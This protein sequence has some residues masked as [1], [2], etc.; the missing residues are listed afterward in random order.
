VTVLGDQLI[1]LVRRKA[2][3]NPDFVYTPPMGLGGDCNYMHED[4]PGCIIGHALAGAGLI[5]R[6][7]A[8]NPG[9]AETVMTLN[10][11]LELGL[12]PTEVT[13]LR[14]VQAWQDTSS[15]W[16]RAVETADRLYPLDY[17]QTDSLGLADIFR[18]ASMPERDL[19]LC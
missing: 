14:A 17:S 8:F 13:W 12:H 11:S 9:N 1:S 10:E 5:D 18:A 7:F 19:V 2:Q 4:G 6:L 3:D 16:S 15:T